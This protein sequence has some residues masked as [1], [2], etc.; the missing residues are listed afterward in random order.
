M[1][2][3]KKRTMLV[4]SFAILSE[5]IGCSANKPPANFAPFKPEPIPY[6]HI[7]LPESVLHISTEQKVEEPLA[8]ALKQPNIGV[9]GPSDVF[10]GGIAKELLSLL[11]NQDAVVKSYGVGGENSEQIFTR[12]NKIFENGHNIVVLSGLT[13]V[14]ET[15]PEN[16]Y[17]YYKK[18]FDICKESNIPVIV[19][20]PTPFAGFSK[21]YKNMQQK[22]DD[23][24]NWLKDQ[25]DIYYVDTSSLGVPI[26]P[27]GPLKL[28][29]KFDSGDGLHPGIFGEKEVARLIYE[30]AL[31]PNLQQHA[32]E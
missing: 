6:Q 23:F 13:I 1:S 2:F 27:G 10:S 26:Y 16:I 15:N 11:E 17:I 28:K 4:T 14:N 24:N 3:L 29:Q 20:S 32:P 7:E 12:F 19:Y 31:K 21:W 5:A 8:K 9:I 18:L 22:S 25:K 30:S